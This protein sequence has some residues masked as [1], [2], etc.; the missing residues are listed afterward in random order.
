MN[1]SSETAHLLGHISGIK[2][3]FEKHQGMFRV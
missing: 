2:Y 1:G 3:Q